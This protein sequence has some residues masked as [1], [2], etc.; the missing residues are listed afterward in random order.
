M[1]GLL[2][3][4]VPPPSV[5]LVWIQG[6][7]SDIVEPRA[8]GPNIASVYIPKLGRSPQPVDNSDPS[9]DRATSTRTSTKYLLLR[10]T[11]RDDYM[12]PPLFNLFIAP[13]PV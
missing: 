2:S 4:S 13:D 7:G 10:S 1:K 5:G 6:E 3:R 11:E 9:V 8:L 12:Y